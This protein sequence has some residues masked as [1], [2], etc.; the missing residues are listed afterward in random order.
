M[1]QGKKMYQFKFHGKGK[2]YFGIW[3]VNILLSIVTLGIYSAWAKVRTNKYFYGNTELNGHRFDYLAKGRDILVGRIIAV[4]LV[5]AWSIVQQ[6]NPAIAGFAMLGFILILPVLMVNNL[7]FDMKMTQYKNVRF[8]FIGTYKEAY[9]TFLLKPI[10]SIIFIGC[11]AALIATIIAPQSTIAAAIL[12]VLALFFGLPYLNAWLFTVA[13][14]FIIDNTRYGNISFT[15]DITEQNIYRIFL[16]FAGIFLAVITVVTVIS[17]LVAIFSFNVDPSNLASIQNLFNAKM[18]FIVCYLMFIA[19]TL[20]LQIYLH[21]R[22]RNYLVSAIKLDG[23]IQVHSSFK[24][25][26]YTS[27][28]IRNVLMT[29]FSLGLARPFAMVLHAKYSALQTSVSGDL[30]LTHAQDQKTDESGAIVDEVS[31][32][33]QLDVGIV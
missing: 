23:Q 28:I 11:T 21:V 27:V 32:A 15:S 1:K 25:L 33:F 17:F 18:T 19:I 13:K 10:A 2:E 5:I 3:I 24:L 12:G 16:K 29:L 4:V 26:P 7:R 31:Q 30:A 22:L 8:N 6:T 20:L 14:R 9:K